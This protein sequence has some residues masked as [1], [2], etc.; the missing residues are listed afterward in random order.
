MGNCNCDSN[1]KANDT[2]EII[3][4]KQKSRKKKLINK[5]DSDYFS[6]SFNSEEKFSNEEKSIKN[7]ENSYRER[8]NTEKKLSH[9]YINN[10]S[11]SQDE[12]DKFSKNSLKKINSAS[13]RGSTK[14][15]S[16]PLVK[17]TIGIKERKELPEILIEEIGYYNGQWKDGKRDGFG[18]FK[19]LDG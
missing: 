15:Y 6:S 8:E 13:S 10:Q 12:S 18:I 3:H 17:E 16:H 11:I 2:N 14:V 4:Q 7:S 19:W 1:L 5:D 9:N